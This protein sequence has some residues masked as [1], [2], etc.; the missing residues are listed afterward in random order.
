MIEGGQDVFPG[1][2]DD[3]Q[4][5]VGYD[6]HAA[7][8]YE[9]DRPPRSRV[10]PDM[11]GYAIF[12]DLDA[13]NCAAAGAGKGPSLVC[14]YNA[15]DDDNDE[16]GDPTRPPDRRS[17][18]LLARALGG[19]KGKGRVDNSDKKSVPKPSDARADSDESQ[20]SDSDNGDRQRY[21]CQWPCL[22][23][24]LRQHCRSSAH[25]LMFDDILELLTNLVLPKF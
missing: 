6:P 24:G 8:V 9:G 11:N 10:A 23:Q 14:V 16:N 17:L 2:E 13:M 15:T 25:L 7:I 21:V 1:W 3:T 12:G 5:R 20:G 18:P 19:D 22:S 4:H